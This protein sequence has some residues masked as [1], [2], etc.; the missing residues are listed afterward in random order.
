MTKEK[1][2]KMELIKGAAGMS[3][4]CIDFTS[5][6]SGR[7]FEDRRY[8]AKNDFG[9]NQIRDYMKEM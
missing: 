9:K 1:K 5:V 7:I 8:K 6:K 3:R 2:Q 4:A